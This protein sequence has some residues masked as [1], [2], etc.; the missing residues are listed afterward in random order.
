MTS[1]SYVV[2]LLIQVTV[3][4][5]V[6]IAMSFTARRNAARRHSIAFWALALV[7]L[8]PLLTL[9][10]PLQ[11]RGLVLESPEIAAS[12][13]ATR[14]V[15][16]AIIELT[17]KVIE[18]LTIGCCSKTALPE[19]LNRN[20]MHHSSSSPEKELSASSILEFP[21]STILCSLADISAATMNSIQ[22]PLLRADDLALKDLLQEKVNN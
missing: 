4:S 10:L 17:P 18:S 8:S 16:V 13:E 9:L 12:V 15:Q 1:Y 21:L 22:L 6:G 14:D 5:G 3:I 2:V 11:W 7:V 20:N 19:S